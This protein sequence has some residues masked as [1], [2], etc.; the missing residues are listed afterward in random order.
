MAN[1]ATNVT[2]ASKKILIVDNEL[3]IRMLLSQALYGLAKE[4][5]KVLTAENGVEALR[6]ID[7][8]RPELVFLDLMMPG[9]N[10][11]DVC[12][13]IKSDYKMKD[14]YIIVLTARS[15]SVDK[16]MSSISGAD[17]YIVKPFNPLDIAQ[18]ARELLRLVPVRST[19]V[20]PTT[21][22][23]SV[24]PQPS[25]PEIVSESKATTID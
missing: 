14:C 22:L 21:P 8:E 20:I 4:G 11:F 5:V 1:S 9:L 17:E 2:Q 12:R 15:Q 13:L 24:S 16:Q 18:R 7:L 6:M 10:G 23:A 25:A 19:P 3:H